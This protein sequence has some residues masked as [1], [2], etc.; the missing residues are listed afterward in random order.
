MAG[1]AR[2]RSGAGVELR[3]MA[4]LVR[5]IAADVDRLVARHAE[6]ARREVVEG[7]AEAPAAA[8]ALGAGAG[9]VAAGGM[10]GSLMLVH[11]LHRATRLPLWG[12][13]GLVGGAMA[14]AGLG[15]ASAGARRAAAIHLVP[16]QTIAVLREDIAWL[17]DQ[18][19]AADEPG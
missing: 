10:L 13:Y 16:S 8:G 17:R 3:E 1:R 2:A 15:L 12:C 4:G 19:G 11:G 9:L 7:L 14:A 18:I 5:V 6:L